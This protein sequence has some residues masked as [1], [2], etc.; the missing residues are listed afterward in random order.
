MTTL[1]S[2]PYSVADRADGSLLLGIGA[3]DTTL[4]LNVGDGAKFPASNFPI[5]IDVESVLV[6]TRTGDV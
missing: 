4:T 5:W 1:P 3:A 6:A 2:V